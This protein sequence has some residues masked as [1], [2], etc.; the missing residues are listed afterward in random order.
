M[1]RLMAAAALC[2]LWGGNAMAD[3]ATKIPTC[4][5]AQPPTGVSSIYMD[6]NGNL[7]VTTAD[8]AISGF[9]SL[10]ATNSSALLSTLTVNAAGAA[11]PAVPGVVKITNASTSAGILYVC[12]LGGT[13]SSTVGIPMI[14]GQIKSFTHPSTSMTVI[15]A[16]TATVIV[17]F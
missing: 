3:T 16:S 4:T 6:A 14:A 7:C 8:Q 5:T 2:A 1:K 17:E 10:A 12:P 15:A 11:W 13:C 9:G